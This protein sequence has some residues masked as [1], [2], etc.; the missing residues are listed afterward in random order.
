MCKNS[1]QN[2]I[3][4]L[5]RPRAVWRIGHASRWRQPCGFWFWDFRQ[6]LPFLHSWHDGRL[7]R[8]SS[9][10][11]DMM[12]MCLC[13]IL[14]KFIWKSLVQSKAIV[15]RQKTVF[16]QK[17]GFCTCVTETQYVPTFPLQYRIYGNVQSAASN[18]HKNGIECSTTSSTSRTKE[19]GH[20]QT[21]LLLWIALHYA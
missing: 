20:C 19:C 21:N 15:K 6:F 2:C 4:V 11:R 3:S 5:C 9:V 16:F 14:A 8:S 12:E 13:D 10:L 18:F 1:I 17:N 7:R